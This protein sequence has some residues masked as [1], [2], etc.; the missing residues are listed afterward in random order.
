MEMTGYNSV[1]DVSTDVV[2][3]EIRR[4]STG[5]RPEEDITPVEVRRAVMHV[6]N[7]LY[8]KW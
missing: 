3:S 5:F 2:G 8:V 4:V 1:R 7:L 6:K